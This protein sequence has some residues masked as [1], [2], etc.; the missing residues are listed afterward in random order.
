MQNTKS[1]D[2]N[3]GGYTMK[4]KINTSDI[5][6]GQRIKNFK[7]LCSVL[8]IPKKYQ[9]CGGDQRKNILR[10]IERYI[11][12]E[13]LGQAYI[14]QEIYKTALPK[15]KDKRVSG[16]Y[17]DNIEPLLYCILYE[18]SQ[19]NGRHN[20]KKKKCVKTMLQWYQAVGLCNLKYKDSINSNKCFKD[21]DIEYFYRNHFYFII[22]GKMKQIL[23]SSLNSLKKRRIIN[24][25]EKL[26]LFFED[27]THEI[28]SKKS[29][30]IIRLTEQDLVK[31]KGAA[32]MYQLKMIG[33]T[34][35]FYDK[36]VE[37]LREKAKTDNNYLEFYNLAFY[38]KVIE[39]SYSPT[40]ITEYYNQLQTESFNKEQSLVNNNKNFVTSLKEF[41]R[42]KSK[43]PLSEEQNNSV[44]D[45]LISI[46]KEWK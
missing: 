35:G 17:L 38:Y 16:I 8:H 5:T 11:K 6:V 20:A 24:Y 2:Y 37:R 30:A 25:N 15:K 31:V 42:T 9:T 12:Y 21:M 13:K 41:F 19:R 40:V 14:V 44:I 36:V 46:Q 18:D 3:N 10:E 34:G 27:Y 39:I 32:N 43:L 4:I 29:E 7:E 33:K 22:D 1:N 23:Y 28:A 45:E 26:E